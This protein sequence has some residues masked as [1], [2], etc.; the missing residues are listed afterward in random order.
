[1][2][3][4]ATTIGIS[5]TATSTVGAEVSAERPHLQPLPAE[6]FDTAPML[7]ARVDHKASMLG[8]A[9]SLL[10]AGAACRVDSERALGRD[11]VEVRSGGRVIACHQSRGCARRPDC[12]W[13]TTSWRCFTA[14]LE[15]FRT[16]AALAQAH[17]A[18]AFTPDP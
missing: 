15:R 10:G 1:M 18:G 7:T 9:V 5:A 17:G 14:C 11:L 13:V 6:P 12:W 2:L 4:M 16:Q 8:A 3:I